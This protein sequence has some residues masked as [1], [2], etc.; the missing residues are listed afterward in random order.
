MAAML[1]SGK[2]GAEGGDGGEEAVGVVRGIIEPRFTFEKRV[3]TVHS[4][5]GSH[6]TRVCSILYIRGILI[7]ETAATLF[8]WQRALLR[9]P[10]PSLSPQAFGG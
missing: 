1:N 10:Y 4:S 3:S 5:T 2:R 8:S 9:Y 6:R 7:L